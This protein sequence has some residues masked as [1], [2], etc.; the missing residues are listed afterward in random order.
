VKKEL[1]HHH[2]RSTRRK[3]NTHRP[4]G[5]ERAHHYYCMRDRVRGEQTL[6]H[7]FSIILVGP[8]SIGGFAFLGKRVVW[9]LEDKTDVKLRVSFFDC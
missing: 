3:S 7:R 1:I 4:L 9:G 2:V 5:N 6:T 8:H